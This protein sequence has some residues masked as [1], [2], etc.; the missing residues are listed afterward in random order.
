MSNQHPQIYQNTKFHAKIKK[1][2]AFM[3]KNALCQYFKTETLKKL[4]KS[5]KPVVLNFSKCRVSCKTKKIYIGDLFLGCKL[6]KLLPY[7]RSA[8]S[9]LSKRKVSCKNENP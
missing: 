2:L 1:I 7:L 4:L 5:L 9:K 3:T 6:E 8:L